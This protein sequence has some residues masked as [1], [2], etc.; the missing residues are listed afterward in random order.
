[1]LKKFKKKEIQNKSRQKD[2][3]QFKFKQSKRQLGKQFWP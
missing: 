1:M 2:L 3:K